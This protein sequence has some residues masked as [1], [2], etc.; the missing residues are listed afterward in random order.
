M[1]QILTLINNHGT[2]V[3]LL[4][5]GY[6]ALKSGSLPLFG[7]YAAQVGALDLSLVAAVTF[8]GGYLGDEL[9]FFVAKRYGAG[10]LK[11]R[12][13]LKSRTDKAITLLDRYGSAYIFIYRYPKGMRT[14]GALPVG[15]TEISWQKFTALN[16]ASALLWATLM[17]GAG[18]FLG[19]AIERAVEQGWGAFSFVLLLIVVLIIALLWRRI[20]KIPGVVVES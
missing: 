10:F 1:E 18:Y 5:F 6:C 13:K 2:A 4:L 11:S 9:R 15:L 19:S 8:A 16:C 17:V 7:G 3:Y 14:I 12:P 20:F